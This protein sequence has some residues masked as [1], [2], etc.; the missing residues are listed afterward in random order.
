MKNYTKGECTLDAI[1]VE[2]FLKNG[3]KAE[4]V[5]YLLTEMFQACEDVH[6]YTTYFIYGYLLIVFA[7]WKW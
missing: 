4:L 1:A 7:M 5:M 6:D 2:E 3:A